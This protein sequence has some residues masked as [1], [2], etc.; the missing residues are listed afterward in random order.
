MVVSLRMV[1][2][3]WS[4]R[5]SARSGHSAY[6][7]PKDLFIIIHKYT[8][9]VF[10]L[11]RRGIISLRMVVSHHEVA[12]TLNSGPSEEQSVLLPAEPSHQ[13]ASLIS[14][15]LIHDA[16]VKL[17]MLEFILFTTQS[18]LKIV[19]YSKKP[20]FSFEELFIIFLLDLN[21]FFIIYF[22]I[23]FLPWTCS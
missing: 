16:I 1:V 7:G 5:T 12:G 19:S 3:N 11:A 18:F 13:P 6:S 10:R 2:G 9:A 23:Y 22:F 4:F 8:V 14:L 21:L 15:F 20:Y 17:F